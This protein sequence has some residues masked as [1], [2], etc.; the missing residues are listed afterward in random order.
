MAS[1]A[2]AGKPKTGEPNKVGPRA[3]KAHKDA[4]AAR[5]RASL[6]AGDPPLSD[7][8]MDVVTDYI[9][10]AAHDRDAGEPVIEVGTAAEPHR[11]MRIAII[12]DDMPFLVDS[13]AA[14]LAGQGLVIDRLLHPVV[15]LRRGGRGRPD[16]ADGR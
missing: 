11:M 10:A 3:S 6:L 16:A 7:G 15:P 8:E 4:L 14:T 12:N 5:I 2:K 1:E 13:I 9:L